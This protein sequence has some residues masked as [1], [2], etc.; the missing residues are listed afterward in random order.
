MSNIDKHN[1]HLEK[2][3]FD[4]RMLD[5]NLKTKR[6]T[7]DEIKAEREKLEDLQDD[8]KYIRIEE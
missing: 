7:V 6:I 8:A 2:L 3:K 4:K 1:L 5:W